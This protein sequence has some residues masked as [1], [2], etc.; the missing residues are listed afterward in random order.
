MNF[1][2]EEVDEAGQDQEECQ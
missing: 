1:N 2:F